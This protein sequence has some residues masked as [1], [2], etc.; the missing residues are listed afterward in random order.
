M[1]D[2]ADAFALCFADHREAGRIL[3]AKLTRF[4]ER[5]DAVVIGISNGGMVVAAE[6]AERLGL[7][8]EMLLVRRMEVPGRSFLHVGAVAE[9]GPVVLNPGVIQALGLD[10]GETELMV[11]LQEV[12]LQD[13]QAEFRRTHTAF[14]IRSKLV[15]LVDDGIVSGAGMRAAIAALR[16]RKAAQI[17]VAVPVTAALTCDLLKHAVEQVVTLAQPDAVGQLDEWYED[18]PP[19]GD[20]A[21]EAL[22]CGGARAAALV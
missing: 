20:A 12:E 13:R 8:L 15:I 1:L 2:R 11:M 19:V 4:A 9:G 22:L 14:S 6:I 3:A 17:V 18:F 10:K 21:L 5:E 16:E 7:P